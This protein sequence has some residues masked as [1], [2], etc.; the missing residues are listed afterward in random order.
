MVFML[1]M[2]AMLEVTSFLRRTRRWWRARRRWCSDFWDVK[3]SYGD[4]IAGRLHHRCIGVGL[5]YPQRVDRPICILEQLG[6]IPHVVHT[7][8]LR[9]RRAAIIP[10]PPIERRPLALTVR[11]IPLA[12]H[13]VAAEGEVEDDAEMR[14]DVAGQEEFRQWWAPPRRIRRHPQRAR[15]ITRTVAAWE[16]PDGDVIGHPLRRVHAAADG[17][18][19]VAVRDGVA[20]PD[21]APR[22]ATVVPGHAPRVDE[23]ARVRLRS[24]EAVHRLVLD[25][26]PGSRVQRHEVGL[27][28]ADAF[29]NVDFAVGG[30]CGSVAP[31]SRPLWMEEKQK[32][33]GQSVSRPV[34]Q[35]VGWSVQT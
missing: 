8:L 35:S 6:I 14:P 18:E 10:I 29:D 9:A 17:V 25:E 24:R 31:E 16:E 33:N 7:T 28:L 11:L 2:V 13:P 5:I 4:T 15:V 22:V 34:G 32:E 20:R 26:A 21:L 3:G 1:R 27:V 12:I 19:A 23:L 30:P